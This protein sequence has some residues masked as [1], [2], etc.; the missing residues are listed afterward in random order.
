LEGAFLFTTVLIAGARQG[1]GRTIT[2]IL[3]WSLSSNNPIAS[4]FLLGS[5][6]L[7]G[8]AIYVAAEE[9]LGWLARG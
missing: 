4:G 6:F 1:G 8:L 5:I 9:S 3:W 7:I 2:S